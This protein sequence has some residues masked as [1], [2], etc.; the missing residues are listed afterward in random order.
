[1]IET[2][3]H[4]KIS[5]PRS[6]VQHVRALPYRNV[7]Q[8][9]L[10][11]LDRGQGILSSF[12]QVRDYLKLYGTKHVLRVP[13]LLHA[14]HE[15]TSILDGPFQTVDWGCGTL[16]AT[17]LLR[18][19]LY[20]YG[21]VNN[22]VAAIGVDPGAAAPAYGISLWGKREKCSIRPRLIRA[23]AEQAVDL[24]FASLLPGVPTLHLATNF[25]DI[26]ALPQVAF[27]SA[28]RGRL[29]TGDVFAAVSPIR[30]ER[31]Q[32]VQRAAGFESNC[33]CP[34]WTKVSRKSDYVHG[35]IHQA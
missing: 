4:A 23:Y 9:E 29:S 32:A 1:M 21:L 11:L 34:D 12:S 14:I 18:D 2:T 22:H 20:R 27:G 8:D 35:F 6:F 16:L 28:L 31:V 17:Q 30:P 33:K 15:Q 24:V 7:P 3:Q 5:T 25:L 13:A 10:Q 26:E 19:R